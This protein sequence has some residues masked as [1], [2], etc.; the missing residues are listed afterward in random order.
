M[1]IKGPCDPPFRYLQIVS[2]LNSRRQ[3]HRVGCGNL[4]VSFH[5]RS[6]RKDYIG[7]NVGSNRWKFCGGNEF[8]RILQR[9]GASWPFLPGSILDCLRDAYYKDGLSNEVVSR[10]FTSA[11]KLTRECV[12]PFRTDS[13]FDC[14]L[15]ILYV[16]LVLTIIDES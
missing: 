12:A 14:I 7:C 11:Y 16:E 6:L 8:C 3:I 1:R 9:T 15:V 4:P 5:L 2:I 10:G 13:L